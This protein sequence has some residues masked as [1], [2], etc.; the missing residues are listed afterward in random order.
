MIGSLYTGI[1]G[2][3]AN[4]S[5]M[6]AIGDNIANVNT[7]AFKSTTVN[8]ANVLN[9][10]L[11]GFTGDELG[12]GVEVHGLSANWDQGSLEDTS[13]PTD[14]AINGEGF[15]ILHDRTTG[16]NEYYTRAGQFTFNLNG[17]LVNPSGFYLQGY[18]YAGAA[19]LPDPLPNPVDIQV[20]NLDKYRNI[21]VSSE[22]ILT[23]VWVGDTDA[24]HTAGTRENLFKVALADFPNIWGL[25]KMGGNL[26]S[27]TVE[28]GPAVKGEPKTLSLGT[29]A[30]QQLEMSNVDLARCFVDMIKTQRAFQANSRVISSSDEILQELINL[31]R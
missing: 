11:N 26:Y 28:S 27:E 16:A 19:A 6:T 12:A 31:K 15:F 3:N 14:L 8:F 2:L 5:A 30:P 29:I 17:Y 4:S 1:S 20:T 25:A 7:T 21:E 23:G 18:D 24:V 10:S 13:N 9:Q 22:G